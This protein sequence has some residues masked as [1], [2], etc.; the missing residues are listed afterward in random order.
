MG[1]N[2]ILLIAI[3]FTLKFEGAFLKAYNIL[4]VLALL[5]FNLFYAVSFYMQVNPERYQ[6]IDGYF[7][8]ILTLGYL[9]LL[10]VA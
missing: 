5:L 6:Y 9:F 2:V 7:V 10:I 3:L 1:L 8:A 4:F